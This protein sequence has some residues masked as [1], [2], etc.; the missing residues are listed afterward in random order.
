MLRGSDRGAGGRRGSSGG[1]SRLFPSQ[2]GEAG[3]VLAGLRRGVF[4]SKWVAVREPLR[5]K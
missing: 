2:R 1:G 5:G 4:S 3:G